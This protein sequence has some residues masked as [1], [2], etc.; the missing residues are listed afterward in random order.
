MTV[1]KVRLELFWRSWAGR[2]LNPRDH[3]AHSA[4][5]LLAILIDLLS[6]I[7]DRRD[8]TTSWSQR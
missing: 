7:V 8:V 2:Q 1:A 4:E 6:D 3:L 5:G